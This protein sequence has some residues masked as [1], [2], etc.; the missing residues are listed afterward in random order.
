[1][2][3]NEGR[4]KGFEVLITVFIKSINLFTLLLFLKT[5]RVNVTLNCS[6]RNLQTWS[7]PT[8]GVNTIKQ[9]G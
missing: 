2:Q 9:R 5:V 8:P 6:K 1:M 4:G 7:D 3:K